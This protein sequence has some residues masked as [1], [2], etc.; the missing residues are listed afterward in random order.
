V[1]A[2]ILKGIAHEAEVKELEAENVGREFGNEDENGCG[3]SD[4]S[5][6]TTKLVARV[7]F[8]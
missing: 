1:P 7:V 2:V 5:E 8:L 6:E 3:E 4:Q